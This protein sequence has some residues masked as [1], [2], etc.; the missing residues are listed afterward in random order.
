[1][2][3]RQAT[4]CGPETAVYT[5]NAVLIGG[6]ALILRRSLRWDPLKW[7]F[8]GDD[9]ANRLLSYAARPPWRLGA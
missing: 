9:E 2:R 5:M 4:L 6:I 8:Q 1:V 3:T 7:E